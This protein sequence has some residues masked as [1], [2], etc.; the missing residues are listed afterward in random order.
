MKVSGLNGLLPKWFFQHNFLFGP[1]GTGKSPWLK[2]KIGD[3]IFIDLLVPEVFRAYSAKPE[4]LREI[5]GGQK[6]GAIIV[7]DEVQKLPKLSIV[8]LKGKPLKGISQ[9]WKICSWLSGCMFF[10]N[11][12]KGALLHIAILYCQE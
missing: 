6:R 10:R 2:E 8:K 12:P 3:A 4:R 7:I 11:A 1:V 9:S 5:I